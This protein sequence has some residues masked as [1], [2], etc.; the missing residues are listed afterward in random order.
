MLRSLFKTFKGDAEPAAA[1]APRAADAPPPSDPITAPVLA[2]SAAVEAA[3]AAPP[4]IATAGA[5]PPAPGSA[6]AIAQ[7]RALL[8]QHPGE[9]DA[10]FALGQH[11]AMAAQHEEAEL[12]LRAA[13][14][15]RPAAQPVLHMLGFSLKALGKLEQAIDIARLAVAAEAGASNTR[16]LMAQTLFFAGH[17][18]EGF[19]HFRARAGVNGVLPAW[20]SALP[21]WEGEP[22]Q[23]TRLLVWLDWGGLGDELMFAR[24]IPRLLREYQPAELHWSVLP[25]NH[26]LLAMVPGV[27]QVFSAEATL[28]VDRHIP[29]LDLPCLFGTDGDTIASEPAYLRA[30]APDVAHWAQRLAPLP[31]L[32][33]G[34]CWA[35]GHWNSDP[36]F[37]RDR[38]AR[39]VPLAL[40]SGMSELPGV[41]VVSL[42]KGKDAG[43]WNAARARI[44]DFEGELT[45]MA[46]TAALIENLDLVVCVDTSVAHLAAALGRPTLLLAA[47][48]IGLFWGPGERTPWYPAMRI[49]R[50]SAA[51][52]WQAEAARAIELVRGYA[53]RGR[54]D[55]FEAVAP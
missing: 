21:R 41:S 9:F 4:R 13:L 20:T 24:Y 2:P 7:A 43:E 5:A 52:E 8:R 55:L 15:L 37:E 36:E 54:V 22:L 44:H 23:Q 28:A 31:G 33:I 11:L 34:L 6:A 27:K 38:L 39:S 49:L 50:Q 18:R 32:K 16:V 30:D 17:Y 35:S 53:Q 12:L 48:G 14:Q 10:L 26:R 46:Q 25:Q 1:D 45:D 3:V 51:G 47:R 19:L 42:Q 29:L 40:L